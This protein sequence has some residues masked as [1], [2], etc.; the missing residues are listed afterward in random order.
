M[1][2][3]T[4]LRHFR[5][6]PALAEML[7]T[8]RATG[9]TGKVFDGL[10]ALST[11]SNLLTLRSLMLDLKPK[12]TLEI[13]LSFGGS[14]LVFGATHRDLGRASTGQHV[15]L[16]PFQATVWDSSGLIAV[17]RAGLSGY[18]DFR[19]AFSAFELPKLVE[20]GEQ[21]EMVYVDG[22]HLFEDVFV[23][24]YFVGR[25][26]ADRGIVAFD[27]STDPHVNKAIRFVRA[28]LSASYEPVDLSPFRLD[29]CRGWR[30]RITRALGRNQLTAFRRIGRP[31]RT[32]NALFHQF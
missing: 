8:R 23:D 7:R 9:K 24:F 16:D 30:Y 20:R 27:D 29:N 22:S 21:F 31:E 25:L 28:N 6:C 1:K 3:T 15:A 12:R 32:W 10:D 11:S 19:P 17:E 5:F 13:G 26:L 18:V 2:R 4:V 14:A